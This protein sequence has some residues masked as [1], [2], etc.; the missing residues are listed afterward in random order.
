VD[1]MNIMVDI[2]TTGT[3]PD[4]A[5]IIQISA[6]RFDLEKKTVDNDMFDRCLWLAPNR[7]WD[8]D[9]RAFWS[10]NARVLND[11]VS[12]GEEP[13]VVLEAFAKWVGYNG[14]ILWAKPT[15]FEQPLLASYFRQ[16]DI[17]MPF[18]Y[19]NARDLATWV[20][21]K[22]LDM[23]ELYARVPFDGDEHNALHDVL[24]QIR[25]LFET[26]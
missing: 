20:H 6:V 10:K 15:T 11:I 19:R 2:E 16:F 3:S 21:A 5:G 14:A 1:Y 26:V 23:K 12:R 7:F 18:H 4:H 9:T 24:Y 22:G 13:R 17:P 25:L 8:E